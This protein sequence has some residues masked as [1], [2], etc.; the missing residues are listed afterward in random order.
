MCE[1]GLLK[2]TSGRGACLTRSSFRSAY[3]LL[4]IPF[5]LIALRIRTS[6]LGFFEPPLLQLFG[7]LPLD[8]QSGCV[9]GDVLAAVE[10]SIAGSVPLLSLNDLLFVAN[11]SKVSLDL[12][13]ELLPVLFQEQELSFCLLLVEILFI[14]QHLHL[15]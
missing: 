1:E 10:S 4:R 6:H 9:V 8:L 3:F 15:F 12:E 2:Q 11:S 14:D 13:S 7:V 5:L